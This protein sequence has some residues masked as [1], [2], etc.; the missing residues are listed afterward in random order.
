[1][2]VPPRQMVALCRVV[3]LSEGL[4]GHSSATGDC[5]FNSMEIFD[6]LEWWL[7]EKIG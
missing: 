7:V 4:L 5:L 2:L 3:A 6:T 1:M